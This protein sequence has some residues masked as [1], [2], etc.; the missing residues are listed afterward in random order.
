[1]T[2]GNTSE[3]RPSVDET[4]GNGVSANTERAPFLGNGFGKAD[5]CSLCGSTVGS[6]NTTV[7]TGGGRDNNYV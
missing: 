1:M 3:G 4:E 7:E 5:D 6:T 2:N